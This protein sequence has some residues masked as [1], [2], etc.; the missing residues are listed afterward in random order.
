MLFADNITHKNYYE[1]ILEESIKLDTPFEIP[2]NWRWVRVETL[3]DVVSASRVHQSDWKNSGIPF[4][5]AREIG[6]LAEFGFVNNE[7]F[8]S[9]ELYNKFPK[10]TLPQPNDLMITAVGTLGKTYIVKDTDKFYYKDASVIS[11]KNRYNINIRFI[12]NIFKSPYIIDYIKGN[13]SGTTV[14]TI[15][16]EKAKKYLIPIPPSKE[17]ERINNI[18]NHLNDLIG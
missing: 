9:E 14:G 3:F 10:S 5:R 1:N 16:I 12:D 18:I 13:I 8:I 6:K 11:L 4:Y 15:T 2:F 7:L 17:Q